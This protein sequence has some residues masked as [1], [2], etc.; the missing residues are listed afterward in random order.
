MSERERTMKNHIPKLIYETATYEYITKMKRNPPGLGPIPYD[1][2]AF[3]KT[4]IGQRRDEMLTIFNVYMDEPMHP[5]VLRYWAEKGLK[6]ELFDNNGKSGFDE[7]YQYSVFTPLDMD[8]SKKYALIYFSHGGG[9]TIEWA[10]NYG[11][12]TLAAR[13]KYIV[14]Y[15]QNGGRSNDASEKEFGRIIGELKKKDYP[16]DWERV[17][18]VGFSSGCEASARIATA[19]PD[20]V[21]AVGCMPDGIPFKNLNFATDDAAVANMKKYRIP[22]IFIGGTVDKGNFPAQWM[23]IYFGSEMPVGSPADAVESLNVWM[24]DVAKIENFTHL[25]YDGV[26]DLLNH[27][28]NPVEKEF[29]MR[30]HKTYSFRAQGTD[31]IGGEFYGANG[32]PVMRYARACGIPHMVWESQAN[33]VWDYIK[34]FRRDTETGESIYDPVACWGER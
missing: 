7:K 12:N 15:A 11:V 16:I 10:E 32:V 13:E 23:N 14:V 3:R 1:E 28:E 2:E 5:N 31:W 6:K 30:F 33:L 25:T 18:A 34:H 27:S 21:A 29:G 26:M 8:N 19:Y 17:Y 22:G 24:R 9:Q 20:V 4:D